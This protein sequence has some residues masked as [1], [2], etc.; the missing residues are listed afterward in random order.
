MA[1]IEFVHVPYKGGGPATQDLI[2]GQIPLAMS[3]L[4]G[5]A[6]HLQSGMLRVLNKTI[7]LDVEK[8][9]TLK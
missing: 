4:P 6:Q 3:A 5:L 7:V 2:A 1:N 9:E 8:I